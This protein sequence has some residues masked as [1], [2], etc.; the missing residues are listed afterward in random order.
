MPDPN[1]RG[2]ITVL[3]GVNGAGKSSVAG[4][5]IRQTGGDYYNPDE[6]TREILRLPTEWAG[7]KV[8]ETDR[9]AGVR[10]GILRQRA[11]REWATARAA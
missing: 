7:W 10:Q 2:I 6:A 5:Y 11:A 9:M 3:A 8:M 4:N 1:S